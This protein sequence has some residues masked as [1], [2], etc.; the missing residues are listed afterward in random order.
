[1]NTRQ[2]IAYEYAQL[3]ASLAVPIADLILALEEDPSISAECVDAQY[4]YLA[5]IQHEQDRAMWAGTGPGMTKREVQ[6]SL[7]Y[8]VAVSE[9]ANCE[10]NDMFGIAA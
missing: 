7:D 8:L 4:D 2:T 5:A 9:G 10:L 3:L 6:T 1:M